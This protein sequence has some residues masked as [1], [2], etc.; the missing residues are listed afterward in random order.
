MSGRS[1]FQDDDERQ[2]MERA[3]LDTVILTLKLPASLK[4]NI[5]ADFLYDSSYGLPEGPEGATVAR[6]ETWILKAISRYN[7]SG[8][9]LLYEYQEDFA[10]W[11]QRHFES[12][13]VLIQRALK[14]HLETNG[15]TLPGRANGKRNERLARALELEYED[16]PTPEGTSNVVP[17]PSERNTE[18]PILRIT[19]Q[20][21]S[22]IPKNEQQNEPDQDTK[23]GAIDTTPFA[24]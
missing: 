5:E 23:T 20:P 7:E 10:G 13:N 21:T 14:S 6:R 4:E 15:I 17:T 9:E 18:T 19:E 8:K 24:S 16:L 12:C 1:G 22:V 2:N 3:H 11:N